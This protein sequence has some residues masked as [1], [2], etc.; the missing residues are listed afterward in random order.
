MPAEVFPR[1]L[2]IQ[3]FREKAGMVKLSTLFTPVLAMVLD[4][5]GSLGNSLSG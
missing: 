4:S 2:Q 3:Y 1:L 5:S